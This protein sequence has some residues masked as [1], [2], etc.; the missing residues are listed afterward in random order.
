M[1]WRFIWFRKNVFAASGKI[2]TCD[3]KS[4]GLPFAFIEEEGSW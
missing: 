3:E 1:Y 4:R 2:S